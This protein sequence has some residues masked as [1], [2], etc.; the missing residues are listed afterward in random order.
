MPH[1]TPPVGSALIGLDAGGLHND[2][3]PH[4]K[5]GKHALCKMGDGEGFETQSMVG[6]GEETAL[7]S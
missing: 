6:V 4:L 2:V 7:A 5:G 3:K 1:E